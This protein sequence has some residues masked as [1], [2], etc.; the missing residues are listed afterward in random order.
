[1]SLKRRMDTENV[2]HL[3]SAFKNKDFM[4]FAG[5]WKELESIILHEITE[6]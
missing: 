2:L 3:H 5:K 6:N 4:N 1:M